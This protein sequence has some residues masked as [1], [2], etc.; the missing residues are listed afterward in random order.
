[1]IDEEHLEHALARVERF[2][3]VNVYD[4][5]FR[6]CR[7]AGCR[8]LWCLLNLDETHPANARDRQ[9]GVVAVVRDEDPD[10]LGGL[11]NRRSLGHAH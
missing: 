7:G 9:A 8:E 2:V 10:S 3:G 4:L 11:E 1:V 6:H 5:P